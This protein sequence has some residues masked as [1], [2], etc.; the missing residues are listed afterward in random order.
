MKLALYIGRTKDFPNIKAHFIWF[1]KRN[2]ESEKLERNSFIHLV[3]STTPAIYEEIDNFT[4]VSLICL[5][6]PGQQ[7]VGINPSVFTSSK[8]NPPSWKFEAV[9][10]ITREWVKLHKNLQWSTFEWKQI[11]WFSN[12]FQSG[13]T[14]PRSPYPKATIPIHVTDCGMMLFSLQHNFTIVSSDFRKTSE[15]IHF[16]IRSRTFFSQ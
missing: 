5:Q 7:S 13:Q 4:Q 2:I 10:H 1:I 9:N 6:C 16:S 3:D 12:P 8:D 15:V 14:I 11:L